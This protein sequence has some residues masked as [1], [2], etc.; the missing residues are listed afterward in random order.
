MGKLKKWA[1]KYD[2]IN[3]LGEGGNADVYLVCDKLE[4]KEFALKELR[5][6]NEEKRVRF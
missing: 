6:R 3:V 2:E 4:G 5:N 1:E